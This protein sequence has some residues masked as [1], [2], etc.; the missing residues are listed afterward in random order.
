M[1]EKINSYAYRKYCDNR[2][3]NYILNDK[4]DKCEKQNIAFTCM[5]LGQ[6]GLIDDIDMCILDGNVIDNAIEA[7]AKCSDPYVNVEI[8]SR[9]G[10]FMDVENP[11]K[12]TFLNRKN[13]F[14]TTKL[15]KNNHGI[16]TKSI[17]DIVAKYNGEIRYEEKEGKVTCHIF[18]STKYVK[19][20]KE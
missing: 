1:S 12:E 10:I 7:A 2:T 4:N 13:P 5:V 17:R 19:K 6:V 15:D 3:L 16:G 20:D 14:L 11:V 18:L 9:G 8:T